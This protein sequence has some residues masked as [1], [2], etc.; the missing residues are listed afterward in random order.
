MYLKYIIA[1]VFEFKL[2]L[3]YAYNLSLIKVVITFKICIVCMY[4]KYSIAV[5]FEFKLYLNFYMHTIQV[6]SKW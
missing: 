2:K 6:L 5:V 4:L 3:L 1:V